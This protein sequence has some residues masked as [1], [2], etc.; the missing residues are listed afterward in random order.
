VAFRVSR[1]SHDVYGCVTEVVYYDKI[2]KSSVGDKKKKSSTTTIDDPF[3]FTFGLHGNTG[4][5]IAKQK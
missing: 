4:L 3:C 2:H 1:A 5:P